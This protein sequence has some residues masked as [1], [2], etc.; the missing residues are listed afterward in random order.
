M[1]VLFEMIEEGSH[2]GGVYV[3]EEEAGGCLADAFL[4]KPDEQ[5]EGVTVSSNRV[6]A[7]LPLPHEAVGEE[8]FEQWRQR[9]HGCTL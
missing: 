9:C 8:H 4:R 2:E 5:S 6:G 3:G 7:R 1:S